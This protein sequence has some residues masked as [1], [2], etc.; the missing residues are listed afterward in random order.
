MLLSRDAHMPYYT[1]FTT[2]PAADW[3]IFNKGDFAIR[4]TY[5]IIMRVSKA[6]RTQQAFV[7]VREPGKGKALLHVLADGRNTG[8][9]KLSRRK[10]TE[11]GRNRASPLPLKHAML[12][13]HI[14]YIKML[15][16]FMT[17]GAH[18]GAGSMASDGSIG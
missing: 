13:G 15:H 5:R 6:S 12:K 7:D 1:L 14:L 11:V 17:F 9:Y 3:T 10:L 18:A 8:H 2:T 16:V 4:Q